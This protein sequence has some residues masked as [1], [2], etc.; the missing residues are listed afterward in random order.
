MRES[1]TLYEG[2]MVRLNEREEH[3]TRLGPNEKHRCDMIG[4]AH[5]CM[6]EQSNNAHIMH[7][8]KTLAC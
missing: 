1:K 5:W 3:I 7:S 6:K 4:T 2:L 8:E